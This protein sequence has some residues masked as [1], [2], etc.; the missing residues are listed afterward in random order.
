MLEYMLSSIEEVEANSAAS[1]KED[2]EAVSVD[3]GGSFN[4]DDE[5]LQDANWP[6][7]NDGALAQLFKTFPGKVRRGTSAHSRSKLWASNV[8]NEHSALLLALLL[9]YFCGLR[10]LQPSK[11]VGN[12]SS[13]AFLD[14]AGLCSVGDVSKQPSSVDAVRDSRQFKLEFLKQCLAYVV[15]AESSAPTR[16][17]RSGA[18]IEESHAAGGTEAHSATRAAA[19]G[20]ATSR[21]QSSTLAALQDLNVTS[22]I[23]MLSDLWLLQREA[24]ALVHIHALLAHGGSDERVEELIPQ[25]CLSLSIQHCVVL[26]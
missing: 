12:L 18:N 23:Y 7:V 9:R 13:I 3:V 10:G 24:L 15:S 8:V 1:S 21:G 14:V 19:E 5:L 22:E 20:S 4:A 26:T 6:P 2:A 11:I 17:T 16:K 25:V